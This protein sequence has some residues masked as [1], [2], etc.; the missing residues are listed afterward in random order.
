MA[1][2]RTGR[3]APGSS[4]ERFRGAETWDLLER[5]GSV[6]GEL[7]GPGSKMVDGLDKVRASNQSA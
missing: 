2:H 5:V 3:K 1:G 7:I 6:S 4:S